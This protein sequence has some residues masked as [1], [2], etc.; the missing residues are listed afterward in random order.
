MTGREYKLA[1]ETA[2][3]V[4]TAFSMTYSRLPIWADNGVYDAEFA[5]EIGTPSRN[6]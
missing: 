4:L 2:P 1:V 5:P 3:P 6:H